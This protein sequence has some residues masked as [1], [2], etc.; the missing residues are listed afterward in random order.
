MSVV[1]IMRRKR[2]KTRARA[3]GV[4]TRQRG[5]GGAA[6]VGTR[7]RGRGAASQLLAA[8]AEQGAKE[9]L[10]PMANIMVKQAADIATN[11]ATTRLLEGLS[12]KW[13][14][15]KQRQR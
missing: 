4:G 10:K 12:Q 8:V 5:R 9:F 3:A 7:Q 14:K 2:G 13:Y 11:Y 1:A 15:R 6:R